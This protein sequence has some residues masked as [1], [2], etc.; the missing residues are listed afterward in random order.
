[1]ESNDRVGIAVA[2]PRD[3]ARRAEVAKTCATL[4]EM[5]M[6]VLVDSIDDRVGHDYSGMPDRLYVIDRDG[7]V[8]FKSGRGPFGFRPAELEQSL[9]LLL[10]DEAPAAKPAR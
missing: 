4:L 8:S 7:R 5:N 9:V 2:Q 3:L 1:M 6:P 10:A